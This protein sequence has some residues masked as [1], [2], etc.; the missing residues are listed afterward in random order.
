MK[1]LRFSFAKQQGVAG[2]G[3]L[4]APQSR[5]SLI[6]QMATL[7]G[8]LPISDA[9]ST[10]VRQPGGKQEQEVLRH[11]HRRLQAG[12]ALSHALPER[13]FS[14]DIRAI[15]AAGE[16][17][18]RLPLMLT[19]LADSLEAQMALRSRLISTLAYPALL[20][21]TA[22][23]VIS[24]MLAF[25]VPSIAGQLDQSGVALPFITKVVLAISSLFSNWWWLMLLLV[26]AGGTGLWFLLRQPNSRTRIDQLLLRAPLVG[27]WI[28][29]I[30]SVRWSRM[31]STMLSAGMPLAE[32]LSTTAPTLANRQ[33][34]QATSDMAAQVRAGTSLSAALPLLPRAPALLLALTRSGEA[35]GRL[36]PLLESAA[37]T[38]DQQLSD[39]SRTALSLAEPVI[40]LVLG[41]F[42]ALIILAVLLPILQ[43][44]SL[45]G[46]GL[47]GI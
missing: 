6:R 39:R 27:R 36:A 38:L 20:I 31:L 29:T 17:S 9:I 24:A 34:Q 12:A 44:N 37:N 5:T 2:N 3:L 19:R 23:L 11:I 10:L 26:L 4:L 21:V 40:I 30:E 32:A 22:L 13:A 7:A 25:V 45:A 43:L 1:P 8:V 16:A 47:G 15:I 33:W 28:A 18:G 35:S 46:A 41:A 14:P 42:V